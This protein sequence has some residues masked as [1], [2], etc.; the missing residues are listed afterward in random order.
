MRWR[1]RGVV[2]P[3][4]YVRAEQATLCVFPDPP[5]LRRRRMT[6]TGPTRKCS[7]LSSPVTGVG[8]PLPRGPGAGRSRCYQGLHGGAC[9]ITGAVR[10]PSRQ[11]GCQTRG[12]GP[13]ST[14]KKRG[15][16]HSQWSESGWKGSEVE[17]VGSTAARPACLSCV[18]SQGGLYPD[19]EK[20][21]GLGTLVRTQEISTGSRAAAT[22]PPSWRRP[23]ADRAV[24]RAETPRRACL[25]ASQLQ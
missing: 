20:E 23:V 13:A 18:S 16:G 7:L 1:Q 2:A 14:E 3:E 10:W 17:G 12:A 6:E 21:L 8:A 9:D 19:L 4:H 22:C 25:L 15:L 5:H 11:T 24:L